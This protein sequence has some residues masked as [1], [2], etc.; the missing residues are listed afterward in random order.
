[1]KTPTI[2]ATVLTFLFFSLVSTVSAQ[3]TIPVPKLPKIKKEKPAES[4]EN[5]TDAS[6]TP[7]RASAPKEYDER[8]FKAFAEKPR[9]RDAVLG[10]VPCYAGKHKLRLQ[11]LVIYGDY[12]P[13]PAFDTYSPIEEQVSKRRTALAELEQEIKQ[14]FAT[15]PNTGQRVETNPAIWDEITTNRDEYITCAL[16]NF[17]EKSD[18]PRISSFQDD[19]K[20]TLQEVKDYTPQNSTRIVQSKYWDWLARAISPSARNEFLN[21]WGSLLQPKQR[22]GFERDLDAIGAALPPKIAA[23]T[24]DKINNF[25][26]RNPAEEG[27]MRAELRDLTGM[28]VHKIGLYQNQWLIEKNNFGLPVNRYKQGAVYGRDPRSDHAYCRIWYVN[29]IQSYSGG[30]TYAASYAKYVGSDFVACPAG[31]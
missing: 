5:K 1:M 31:K 15:R 13:Y 12:Y 7:V 16:A 25:P 30:G 6:P 26:F 19:V 10:F 23:F 29:I 14:T 17:E 11:D 3:F 22:Q 20:E 21:K 8:T 28:V 9:N 18:D 27:M 24:K 2:S 4:R